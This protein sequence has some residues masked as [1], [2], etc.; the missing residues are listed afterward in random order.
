MRRQI[1]QRMLKQCIKQSWDANSLPVTLTSE[2]LGCGPPGRLKKIFL[3]VTG[4]MGGTCKLLSISYY[5][6]VIRRVY[7]GYISVTTRGAPFCTKFYNAPFHPY[8]FSSAPSSALDCASVTPGLNF[9]QIP[10]SR[11]SHAFL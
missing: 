7:W 9:S 8:G 11:R 1:H 2:G 5:T 3:V 4:I 10:N 6:W